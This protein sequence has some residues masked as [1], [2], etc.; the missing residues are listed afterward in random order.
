MVFFIWIFDLTPFFFVLKRLH[1]QIRRIFVYLLN[2]A[3]F[4]LKARL[5]LRRDL[6]LL[7]LNCVFF[8]LWLR[9]YWVFHARSGWWWWFLLS[10]LHVSRFEHSLF[11][12]R[13][14]L[15]HFLHQKIINSSLIQLFNLKDRSLKICRLRLYQLLSAG[16]LDHLNRAWWAFPY[17]VFCGNGARLGSRHKN[18]VLIIYDIESYLSTTPLQNLVLQCPPF[19]NE[20]DILS[21]YCQFYYDWV[22]QGNNLFWFRWLD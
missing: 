3:D 12:E 8:D 15:L 4:L 18:V 16:I 11:F 19:K 6:L 17:R 21:F 22:F 7:H 13:Y 2:H 14:L 10:R 5:Q 20:I 9:P 1:D